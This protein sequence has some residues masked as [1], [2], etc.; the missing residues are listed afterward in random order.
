M[1]TKD[2]FEKAKRTIPGL[3][4]NARCYFTFGCESVKEIY[5]DFIQI[6]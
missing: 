1:N 6:L 3:A 5:F 4:N 2:S